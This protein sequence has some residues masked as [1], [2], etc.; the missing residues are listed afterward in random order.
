VPLCS[1]CAQSLRGIGAAVEVAVEVQ[2]MAIVGG[3]GAEHG[4]DGHCVLTMFTVLA[5]FAVLT[6]FAGTV[7]PYF[8]CSLYF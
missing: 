6:M 2:E 3:V 7:L 4:L 1:H 5:M 8:W